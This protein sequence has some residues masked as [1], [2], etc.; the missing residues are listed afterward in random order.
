[1][2]DMRIEKY[3]AILSNGIEI[4]RYREI[5]YNPDLISDGV[6]EEN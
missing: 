5:I 6:N 1:M 3:H 2:N 4:T